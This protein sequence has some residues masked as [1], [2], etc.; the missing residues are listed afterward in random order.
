MRI[1]NL[2]DTIGKVNFGIWNAA[3]STADALNERHGISSVLVYPEDDDSH[4]AAGRFDTYKIKSLDNGGLKQMVKDLKL[5]KQ[6]D[7][8]AT[9]GTWR[10]A[11]L[12]GAQ[13]KSM[14]FKWVYAPHGMLEPWSMEQKWLKK[15]VY[16]HLKEKPAGKKADLVRA[17]S[18]VECRNLLEW[19]DKAVHIANGTDS[20]DYLNIDKPTDKL[21]FLFMAR[22]HYK[23]GVLP[24]VQAWL[25]TCGDRANSML[26]IA[27]PDDGE[28]PHLQELIANN[29]PCNIKYVGAVYGE[30]KVRLLSNSHFYV[31][32][33]HSEGF[34]TSVVEAMNYGCVPIITKGCNFPEAE[35]AGLAIMT[36]P[37]VSDIVESLN[38]ALGKSEE[39]LSIIAAN[40]HAFIDKY[41]TTVSIA[42][43]QAATFAKLLPHSTSA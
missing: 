13:L 23:K 10:F 28:L 21:H 14:G 20:I 36:T 25:K 22:L 43:K 26:T 38:A 31:L 18:S 35:T 39:E 34:P 37:E 9:H 30:E 4:V 27:G 24:L 2:V 12:W 5:N 16:F 1:I 33:S 8:I 40:C 41:F 6:Q 3:I 17:V 11:T 7:V 32:P 15:Q 29:Q 19:F 42:D